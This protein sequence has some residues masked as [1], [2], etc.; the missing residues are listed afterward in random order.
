M[1]ASRLSAAILAFCVLALSASC[2][3]GNA[4]APANG[5]VSGEVLVF[6]ASSLTDAL[7][8][9]GEAFAREHPGAKVTFSFGA[10]SALA[11]QIN[12][13]ARAD[14]FAAA[15]TTQMQAVADG[16]R[17][18]GPVRVFATNVPVVVKPKGSNAARRFE[19]LARPG[20]RL[21]LAGPEVPIGKYSREVFER[22]SGPGGVSPD[23]AARVLANVR[24][25][26]ANARAV[27][28]KVQLGEA[29]AGVV[30]RSDAAA[31]GPAVDVLAVPA[32]FVVVATYPIAPLQG[33]KN[34]G[35]AAAF[36]D[37]VLSPEGQAILAKYGFGQPEQP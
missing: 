4:A 23:F 14:V 6:A 2:G 10:S 7:K 34:A 16:G 29:D 18:A 9:S 1:G 3:G 17:L 25:N 28:A 37:F 36:V 33:G 15:D 8:E 20:L 30:Y 22:A 35:G 32:A 31:A 13:A 26:E 21:V 5:G 27:L 12:E 24:S 19:D 11:T